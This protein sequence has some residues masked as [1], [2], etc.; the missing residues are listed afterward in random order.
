MAFLP[1]LLARSN[2]ISLL[3]FFYW[4]PLKGRSS[5]YF[6]I[7]LET[8]PSSVS[9]CRFDVGD[10]YTVC[11]L[12]YVEL[13]YLAVAKRKGNELIRIMNLSNGWKA[14]LLV[15]ATCLSHA[16]SVTLTG[17]IGLISEFL[18]VVKSFG[19]SILFLT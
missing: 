7:A 4:I 11:N 17:W 19:S 5:Y 12:V 2:S 6:P 15:V 13:N 14:Y 10:K 9:F 16:I 3:S 8:P 18:N 1:A